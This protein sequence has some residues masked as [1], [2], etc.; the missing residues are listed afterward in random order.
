MTLGDGKT[1]TTTATVSGDVELPDNQIEGVVKLADV[2]GLQTD[3]TGLIGD[4]L[5]AVIPATIGSFKDVIFYR[6]G[7]QL[8]STTAD[9]SDIYCR[10]TQAGL[11]TA[12]VMTNDGKIYMSGSITVVEN[13]APAAL[14]SFTIEDDY[15]TPAIAYK[16][17]D[18]KAVVTVVMNK[19]YEGTLQLFKT[20]D[21]K[22][23]NAP[24]EKVSTTLV[25]ADNIGD[26]KTMQTPSLYNTEKVV[27]GN[28]ACY[29]YQDDVTGEA[30]Y[31]FLVNDGGLTR[32]TEYTIVF[33][34]DEISGDTPGSGEENAI[35]G[36]KAPYITAP[37]SLDVTEVS[38]GG[39]I[40]IELL[41][42]DG[43]ALSWI[44]KQ[45]N[46]AVKAGD[47]LSELKVYSDT[48]KD[49]DGTD[50]EVDPAQTTFDHGVGS[51]D[52]T[53]TT[54]AF[55]YATAKTKSGLFGKDS[56][57]LA[58]GVRQNAS[59][60]ADKIVIEQD[61]KDPY[62]AKIS[63]T[64]LRTDGVVYVVQSYNVGTEGS[65]LPTNLLLKDDFDT[66]K[67]DEIASA[68]V[69][70]GT[71]EIVVDGAMTKPVTDDHNSSYIAI[72]IPDDTK[73]Y[74]TVWT[75]DVPAG[76]GTGNKSFT[77]ERKL[78]DIKIGTRAKSSDGTEDAQAALTKDGIIY[79]I[80]GV[81]Q[82][83]DSF[84]LSASPAGG[85]ILTGKCNDKTTTG[86]PDN[87]EPTLAWAQVTAPVAQPITLGA[88][89][90]L[91]KDHV[92]S[93]T[94]DVTDG[95]TIISKTF[96]FKA[97]AANKVTLSVE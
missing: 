90:G 45:G 10:A 72:F 54:D 44:T 40:K 30:T 56:I 85:K 93:V 19:P 31:K 18:D 89:T 4:W 7:E 33:D 84:N 75:D 87:G 76:T 60:S 9:L 17:K 24:V 13:E 5:K 65:T 2:S 73:N 97:T 88:I 46:T 39:T 67:I 51:T 53:G 34:Q 58:S 70:A 80:E 96:K 86:D 11:Y 27:A 68:S 37:A 62:D 61:K 8:N 66:D 81:D 35:A 64:N 95:T 36:V 79:T 6:D 15:K 32:G 50:L 94:A 22:F 3:N 23:S 83:G 91:T 41:D 26:D 47:F 78:V 1:L 38:N 25:T 28:G 29:M 12:S 52:K 59:D 71:K 57:E 21:K 63:F 49:K 55:Y 20:S 42:K 43:K 14:R 82:F 48:D 77:L 16:I 74:G 69:E 92:Y